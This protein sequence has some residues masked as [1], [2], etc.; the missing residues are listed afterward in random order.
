MAEDPGMMRRSGDAARAASDRQDMPPGTT[1]GDTAPDAAASVAMVPL[2]SPSPRPKVL[3]VDDQPINVQALHQVFQADHQVF[4]ATSGEQALAVAA[5]R[6]P[7]LVLLDVMMPGM[8]GYEVCRRLKSDDATRDIPVIFV[9]AHRDDEAETRGLDAGAVDFISK[10]INPRIVRARARTHLTLK[11]QSDL[12]RQWVYIDGLTGVRN[13]RY[14]D[15]RLGEE[16]ARS[17]RQKT[18]LSLL[19]IDVD[20]FKR[21]NDRHG[22]AAGDAC[23]REVARALG[24]SMRRPS[25]LLARYGGEEFACLLPETDA[26]G[27]EALARQ[28]GERVRARALSH[29]DSEVSPWVTVSIGAC[30]KPGDLSE[31]GDPAQADPLHSLVRQADACL[32][33]A[34]SAG[35]DRSLAQPL[36]L[37]P[38]APGEA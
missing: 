15:E 27:A 35:R 37:D 33:A 5:R 1:G 25:D 34:K 28:L 30:T 7:D 32:Y 36:K 23:L 26:A 9:T 24:E 22:H 8:D 18:A 21:F 6:Q 17:M 31:L 20:F 11:R 13:R 3:V 12:L 38:A 29:G 2:S 10:P 4:M 14:F 16:W 19:L